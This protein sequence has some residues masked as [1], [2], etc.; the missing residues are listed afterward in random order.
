MLYGNLSRLSAYFNQSEVKPKAIM[1]VYSLH[2]F[3]PGWCRLHVLFFEFF[4]GSL[5]CLRL[6][7]LDKMITVVLVLRHSFD[8]KADVSS[9]F[10]SP[11]GGQSVPSHLS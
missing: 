9:S 5:D 10:Q 7:Y 4:I 11:F 2:A 3:F 1:T 6:L 8:S